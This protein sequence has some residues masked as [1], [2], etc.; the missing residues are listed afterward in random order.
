MHKC[1]LFGMYPHNHERKR[2]FQKIFLW[3]ISKKVYLLLCKFSNRM[4]TSGVNNWGSQRQGLFICLL[5]L[6]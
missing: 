2:D 6:K 1:K 3:L 5:P 4:M